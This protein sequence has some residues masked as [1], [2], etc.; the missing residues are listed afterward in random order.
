[1]TTTSRFLGRIGIE[2]S[3][4]GFGCWAI[5]GPVWQAGQPLG[6]G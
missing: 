2:V 1:M 4:R 6:G 5:G 3:A